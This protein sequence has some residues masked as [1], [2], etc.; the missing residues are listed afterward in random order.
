MDEGDSTAPIDPLTYREAGG[1][2]LIHIAAFTGDLRTVE[3]LL[4]AGE[5]V[6]AIGDMGETPGCCRSSIVRSAGKTGEN[7]VRRVSAF[8]PK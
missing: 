4:D 8:H 3:L 1:D 6:D 7:G 2:H 5:D